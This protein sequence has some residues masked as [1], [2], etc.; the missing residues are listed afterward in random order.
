MG[1]SE[2]AVK[3]ILRRIFT[4]N[5]CQKAKNASQKRF[6][7]RFAVSLSLCFSYS[8][9]PKKVLPDP[10]I[11]FA[12]TL[13][14]YC[15]IANGSK[16]SRCDYLKRCKKQTFDPFR[17]GR[18]KSMKFLAS[19]ILLL[20]KLGRVVVYDPFKIIRPKAF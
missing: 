2:L 6:S 4:S 18:A 13:D 1:R 19:K 8:E 11:F 12:Q 9:S 17:N 15:H 20:V 10:G 3:R 14:W 16:Q 5:K 7:R